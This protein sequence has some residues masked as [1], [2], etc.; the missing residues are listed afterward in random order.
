M[1]RAAAVARGGAGWR[2]TAPRWSARCPGR[3]RRPRGSPAW[4]APRRTARPPC[5]DRRCWPRARRGAAADRHDRPAALLDELAALIGALHPLER[6]QLGV[7]VGRG[8]EAVD[9]DHRGHLL[10]RLRSRLLGHLAG[11]APGHPAAPEEADGKRRAADP[12][13]AQN[14]AVL[15]RGTGQ[16]IV[17]DYGFA[18]FIESSLYCSASWRSGLLY[19]F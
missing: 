15:S 10:A 18:L 1:R 4:R 19:F 5:A 7:H 2:P 17:T 11:A 8:H 13:Q 12:A 9:A 14:R 6:G 16:T 3:R